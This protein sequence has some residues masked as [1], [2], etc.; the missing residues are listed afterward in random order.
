MSDPVHIRPATEGDV[1]IIVWLIAQNARKG[2]LLPRDESNIREHLANF[3]VAEWAEHSSELAGRVVGCGSLMPISATLVELRSLAVDDRV[4]GHGIGQRVVAALVEEARRRQFG[5]IFALTRAVRFFERCGFTV[6]PKEHFPEKVWNDCVQCP[7]LENC[8]EVA[9]VLP[10]QPEPTAADATHLREARER[11]LRDIQAGRLA[12]RAVTRENLIPLETVTRLATRAHLP[13]PPSRASRR[14]VK[15]VVLAYNGGLDSSAAVP[16]L[17]ETYGCEVVCFMADVGQHED[18]EAL[19]RRALDSGASRVIIRDL[20][21][22]FASEYLFPLVQSGAIYEG[23]YLL[24]SSISRPLIAKHQVDVA[25]QE[26]ADA[27][28]HGA[29]GKGNDQVRFE[30]AYIALDPTLQVIAPWREWTFTSR[31]QVHEYAL[32]RGVALGDYEQG[33]YT[34]DENLW[35]FNH[36]G[37]RL[38]DLEYE[39]EEHLWAW[40]NAVEETPDQPQYIE[41][42]FVS[43]I[44][45]RL[46]GETLSGAALIER[47]N[48]IGAL[49][50]I[51]RVE[52]VENRLIG[53]KSRGLDEA[54]AGFILRAAH[55][56]LE[57]VTLD[58]EMAHFKQII[59][60]KYAEVIYNGLWLT[61][62]RDALQAFISVS[63]RDVTGSVRLKLFKGHV[64]VAQ[65]RPAFSLYRR[66]LATFDDN[67]GYDHNDAEGFIRL[68]SLP[69]RVKAQLDRRRSKRE[70][71]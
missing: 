70:A 11:V 29:T 15:K 14:L 55:Q 67:T 66:D 36:E 64:L 5:T 2:G 39:P 23:K 49:H 35:H 69:V 41:I 57:E 48:R 59:A 21:E 9:V 10:L 16:W 47:L 40:T 60:L 56:A 31:R 58:R 34:V 45:R 46:N 63:Q 43:G 8:D 3:L 71:G 52:L 1:P 53:L 50:G 18:F 13:P 37:G 62:L 17:L 51:G 42:E 19:R 33:V 30:L 4:R 54:P 28:A 22:E 65:R 24:G 38:E 61:P 44:P 32:S 26:G 6:A 12:R 68:Y 25:H 27:V 20:R 7:M